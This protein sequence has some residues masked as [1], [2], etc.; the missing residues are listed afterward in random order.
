[1]SIFKAQ[2]VRTCD[3]YFGWRGGGVMLNVF[4]VMFP[5]LDILAVLEG[6]QNEL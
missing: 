5:C 6:V 4:E 3:V 2:E 1:M